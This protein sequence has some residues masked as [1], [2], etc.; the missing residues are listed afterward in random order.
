MKQLSEYVNEAKK[1]ASD[2]MFDLLMNE[3]DAGNSVQSTLESF[4]KKCFDEA[5]I[6]EFHI[7]VGDAVLS[8]YEDYL[9]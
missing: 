9:K 7:E 4:L 8:I 6:K 2:V 5:P 1:S 3:F